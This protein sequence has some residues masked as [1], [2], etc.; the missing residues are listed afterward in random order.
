[1][2]EPTLA[3]VFGAGA[4]QTAQQIVIQKADLASV[5]LSSSPNNRAEQLLVAI[6]MKAA[7]ALTESAR[8]TDIANRNVSVNYVGQDLVNQGGQPLRRDAFT[9]LAYKSTILTTVDPD[10][11]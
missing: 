7:L 1:M 5:G 6:M 10:D 4:S 3:E 11:Y 2:A 8:T 9:L